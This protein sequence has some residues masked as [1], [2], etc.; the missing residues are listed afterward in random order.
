MAQRWSK[1]RIGMRS[2]VGQLE[3]E[4][5]LRR[6]RGAC[7]STCNPPGR[8]LRQC[9]HVGQSAAEPRAAG[10]GSADDAVRS[11]LRFGLGRFNTAE[12]VET[13]IE[14]VADSVNRLRKLSS[15]AIESA[16]CSRE[17]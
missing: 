11:S 10:I 15:M 4:F 17:A 1:Q 13:A 5:W 12:E 9:V 14:V 7:C 8:Q 6:R 2:I 3:P 16:D